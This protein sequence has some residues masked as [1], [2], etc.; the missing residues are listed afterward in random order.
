MAK[1]DIS[2]RAAEI[3]QRAKYHVAKHKNGERTGMNYETSLQ[4]YPEFKPLV[5]KIVRA[6]VTQINA[7]ADKVESDMP[8]K[9][10]FALEEIIRELQE[11]V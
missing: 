4:R 10:Q 5:D 1:E 8:Y 7:E 6:V 2:K 9:A 11:R 3:I